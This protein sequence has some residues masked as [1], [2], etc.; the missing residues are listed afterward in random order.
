MYKYIKYQL[1]GTA[2]KIQRAR[3]FIIIIILQF[4]TDL[5]SFYD[6]ENS[7]D[8]LLVEFILPTIWKVDF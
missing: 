3:L 8:L 2:L 4:S 1:H 6:A 5:K 7:C